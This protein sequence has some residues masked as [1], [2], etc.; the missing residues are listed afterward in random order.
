VIDR[1]VAFDLAL[2][3]YMAV[4]RRVGLP[5][6]GVSFP[7]HFL[8]RVRMRAGVLVL[9]PFAGRRAAVGGRPARAAAARDPGGCDGRRAGLR[10][11]ARPV[12]EAATN[13]QIL[14]ACCAT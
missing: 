12:L 14:A 9:D 7:G 10:A 2:V 8:V 5:L 4:G 1:K 6:E 13:R 3:L 11:A